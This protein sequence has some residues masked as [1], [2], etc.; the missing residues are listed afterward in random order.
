MS[1]KKKKEAAPQRPK[2]FILD[3]KMFM[4]RDLI[5]G[6]PRATVNGKGV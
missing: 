1:E 2:E 4:N 6:I 5:R 3:D